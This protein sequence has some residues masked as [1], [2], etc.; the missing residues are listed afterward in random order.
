MVVREIRFKKDE[1]DGGK[2]DMGTFRMKMQLLLE[3]AKISTSG[4]SY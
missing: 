2:S 4:F 3:K 1:E